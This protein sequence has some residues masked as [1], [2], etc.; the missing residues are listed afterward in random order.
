MAGVSAKHPSRK[1]RRYIKRILRK[2]KNEINKISDDRIDYSDIPELDEEWFK[3]AEIIQ[4]KSKKSIKINL[5]L[6]VFDWY[7][8]QGKN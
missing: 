1:K 7:E 6:D 3:K 5:D 2:R 4:S 8:S